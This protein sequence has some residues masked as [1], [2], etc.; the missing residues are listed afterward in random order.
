MENEGNLSTTKDS[1]LKSV[2]G[3]TKMNTGNTS[4]HDL[5]DNHMVAILVRLPVKTIVH[6]KC[7]CRDWLNLITDSHFINLHLTESP[8]YFM[9]LDD[10]TNSLRLLDIQEEDGAN[11]LH[12]DPI[13]SL[14]LNLAPIFQNAQLFV[15]GSVNGLICLTGSD[16]TSDMAYICNPITREYMILPKQI[17]STE[18]NIVNSY[19]FG[20]SSLTGEYKVM[21]VIQTIRTSQAVPAADVYTL[22][23]GQWRRLGHLAYF[24]YGHR[25]TFL[26][27]HFHW[28][29]CDYEDTLEKICTFDIDNEKFQLFPSPPLDLEE[30]IHFERMMG[31]VKGCLCYSYY[32]FCEFTMW[33]MKVYGIKNS[34]QKE[35]LINQNICPN[36]RWS[37]N[38][39]F[40]PIGS[41]K[42]GRFLMMY[43]QGKLFVYHPDTS[44]TQETEFS[45]VD[46]ISYR[47]SFLKLQTFESESVHK[48]LR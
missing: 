3:D 19:G 37:L 39:H 41:L 36:L 20:V 30:D 42:D 10:C 4:I 46:A 40:V 1:L 31:V 29:I 15:D 14:N 43:D 16:G 9:L 38:M 21:R 18:C 34:W 13:M 5:S 17:D 11:H 6:C 45:D 22:G 33:V 27:N 48:F 8:E 12:H 25:G 7:V 35:V 28:H 32:T 24:I 47:P 44:T 2:V 23:T 26:N